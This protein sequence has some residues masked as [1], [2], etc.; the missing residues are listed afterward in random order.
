MKV[1]NWQEIV[2]LK[3]P[4]GVPCPGCDADKWAIHVADGLTHV[5]LVC[6]CGNELTFGVRP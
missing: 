4:M 2:A 5:R 6:A 1:E 3:R